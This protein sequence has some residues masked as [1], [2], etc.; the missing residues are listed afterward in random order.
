MYL[1]EHVMASSAIP[2]FFPPFPIGP[3]DFGDG[4]LRNTAPLSPAVHVGA[5]KI[6]VVGVRRRKIENLEDTPQVKASLGRVLGVLTNAIFMDAIEVDLDR[7]R[8]INEIVGGT[9]SP[10]ILHRFRKVETFYIL[11]AV[12]RIL[13]WPMSLICLE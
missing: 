6:L 13:P 11:P 2:M 4:C 12:C 3:R 1:P 10:S 8:I 7:M 5:E 9:Q